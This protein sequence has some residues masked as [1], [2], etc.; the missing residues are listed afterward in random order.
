MVHVTTFFCV[1]HTITAHFLLPSTPN[2]LPPFAAASS[3]GVNVAYSGEL[4]KG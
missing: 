3:D 4:E 2:S 1:T